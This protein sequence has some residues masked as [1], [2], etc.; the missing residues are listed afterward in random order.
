MAYSCLAG[1]PYAGT[2]RETER[3]AERSLS[4]WGQ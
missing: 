2:G 3:N 4:D 1:R